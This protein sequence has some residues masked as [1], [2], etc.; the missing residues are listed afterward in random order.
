[1][2]RAMLPISSGSMRPGARWATRPSEPSSCAR[3]QASAATRRRGTR[4]PRPCFVGAPQEDPHGPLRLPRLARAVPALRTPRPCPAGRAGGLRRC[5]GLGPLPSLGTAAGHSGFAWAWLGAALARTSFPVGS[6]SAPGYRYHPAIVAQA[7]ATLSEMFPGP[8]LARLGH[9]P[10]AQRRHHGPPL[11]REAERNARLKECAGIIR[12]LLRGSGL[13][14]YGRYRGGRRDLLAPRRRPPL[15][16]AAVTEATAEF[17]AAGPT[18]SS[19]SAGS[20]TR[21]ARSWTPSGAGGGEG[22]T[23]VMQVGLSWAPTEEEAA[24]GRLGA[25]AHQ[26][27]GGRGELGAPT[28]RA[29]RDRPPSMSGP[30][31]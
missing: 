3:E 15:L 29:V 25:V 17:V 6:I 31:T 24:P 10:A 12:R 22:K 2:S 19:P 30:R 27:P 23:L 21:S 1:L 18:G 4:R 13:S 11:A 14:H 16:G 28:P 26:R 20:P 8:L 5:K 9:G 7:A